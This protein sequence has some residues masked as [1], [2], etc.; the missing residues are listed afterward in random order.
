MTFPNIIQWIIDY[1]KGIIVLLVIAIILGSVQTLRLL[2]VDNSLAIWFLEDNA[3]YQ[4]YL[5]FQEEQGSDEV[6]IIMIPTADA[7]SKNHITQLKQL[8]QK[9]DTLPY[10]CLLYTSP[11]PRD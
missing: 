5:A 8:H 1:K 6:V 10:V 9:A 2:T 7:L 4:E 11:S 3:T